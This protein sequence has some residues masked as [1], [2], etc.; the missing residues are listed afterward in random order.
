MPVLARVY[1][2]PPKD[3][4]HLKLYQFRDLQRDYRALQEAEGV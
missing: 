4:Q 2:I 1:S 3:Q